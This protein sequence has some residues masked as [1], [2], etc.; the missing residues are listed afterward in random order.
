MEVMEVWILVI[1]INSTWL[2][3]GASDKIKYDTSE[4]CY[5][6]LELV[7]LNDKSSAWCSKKVKSND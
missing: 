2:G 7:R 4:Q 6:A 5:K 1:C 3:C